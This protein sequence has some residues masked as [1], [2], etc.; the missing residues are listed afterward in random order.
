M[1]AKRRSKK[2]DLKRHQFGVAEEEE[3]E[4]GADIRVL[5]LDFTLLISTMGFT[6]G[7]IETASDILSFSFPSFLRATEPN[8][9]NND[10]NEE[11]AKD[12]DDDDNKKKKKTSGTTKKTIAGGKEKEDQE[13][14]DDDDADTEDDEEEGFCWINA[15]PSRRD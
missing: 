13:T 2:K 7:N 4:D 1:F 5:L 15:I 6:N 10:G 3:K 12:D 11:N 8:K 14:D 9:S